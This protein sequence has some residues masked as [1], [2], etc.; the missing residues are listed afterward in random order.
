VITAAIIAGGI[1]VY[2]LEKTSVKPDSSACGAENVIDDKKTS[3]KSDIVMNDANN[4]A[5][6]TGIVAGAVLIRS[7]RDDQ[8]AVDRL[9]KGLE[10]AKESGISDN[11]KR[12]N[13]AVEDGRKRKDI[14]FEIYLD[15]LKQSAEY[16]IQQNKEQLDVLGNSTGS[17][18]R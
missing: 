18:V 8:R 10:L 2:E 5:V 4:R 1:A 3:S 17:E 9:M 7:Y 11:I 6:Q 13:Q 14:T 15:Q 16:S 12:S